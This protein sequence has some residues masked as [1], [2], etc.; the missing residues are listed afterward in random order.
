MNSDN[1]EEML[2]ALKKFFEKNMKIKETLTKIAPNEHDE[3]DEE[4]RIKYLDMLYEE[5]KSLE[6]DF[7]IGIQKFNLEPDVTKE[8]MGFFKKAR[9]S[10]LIGKFH[11]GICKEIFTSIFSDM[12]SKLIEDIKD[13][14]V[15]YTFL[16]SSDLIELIDKSNTV[17][18]LLHVIHSYITNNNEILQAMPI[19]GEKTINNGEKIKLY[20]EENEIAK[21]IFDNFPDIIDVGYTDI[22]GLKDK[23]LIMIRDR[24]HALSIDLD[25]SRDDGIDVSYFVP[26]LCNREMI[27]N[28]PGI[29]KSGIT[30]NGA[31]GFFVL[32]RKDI[33]KQ[34]FDFIEKVPTDNDIPKEHRFYK[35]DEDEIE[36]TF[37][38]QPIFY[39]DDIKK[40]AMQKGEEGRKKSNIILIQEKIK[41][42]I[43]NLK[44]KFL[45]NGREETDDRD[46]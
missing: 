19:I 42:V 27:E 6:V 4:S 39:E 29:N 13:K 35:E 34:L 15:G 21:K 12:D 1:K 7:L 26:K 32:E 22:I 44:E 45:N 24:G 5:L 11:P 3:L 8:L 14:C 38:P 40:M 2:N 18:E 37:E 31:T 30:Q 17:N 28:L 25:T 36:E 33:E 9:E 10:I 16:Q 41:N 23:V 43:K 20:G 46:M